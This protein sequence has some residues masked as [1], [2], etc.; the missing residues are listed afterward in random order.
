M[1]RIKKCFKFCFKVTAIILLL[2]AAFIGYYSIDSDPPDLSEFNVEYPEVPK[3]ENLFYQLRVLSLDLEAL[4]D[5][6]DG[7][8]SMGN[9]PKDYDAFY[10]NTQDLYNRIDKCLELKVYVQGAGMEVGKTKFN[11]VGILRKVS[12]LLQVRLLRAV[13]QGEQRLF[14][15][16]AQQYQNYL[17]KVSQWPRSLMSYLV[18]KSSRVGFL[19]LLNFTISHRSEDWIDDQNIALL[20]RVNEDLIFVR[21][22]KGEA[23]FVGESQEPYTKETAKQLDFILGPKG[24]YTKLYNFSKFPYSYRAN[25]THRLCV[26]FYD[27]EIKKY[28]SLDF[29]PSYRTEEAFDFN[30]RFYEPNAVGKALFSVAGPAIKNTV[31]KVF[32]QKTYWQLLVLKTLCKRYEKKHGSLP[33]DLSH[34]LESHM[35]V[36]DIDLFTGGKVKYDQKKRIVYS[37]GYESDQAKKEMEDSPFCKM[38]NDDLDELIDSVDWDEV[39]AQK[40]DQE[41]QLSSWARFVVDYQSFKD[42]AGLSSLDSKIWVRL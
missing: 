15:Q 7:Q 3:E 12:W 20:Q 9:L 37:L 34:I 24:F 36:N 4:F 8:L 41:P 18:A 28:Q 1:S 5:W 16:Y 10:I 6:K 19:R 31:K 35:D 42:T 38:I 32:E 29:F 27:V 2:L 26:Q 11:D 25:K 30:T 23:H 22:L 39:K 33:N 13:K 21:A 17:G 14:W 40:D